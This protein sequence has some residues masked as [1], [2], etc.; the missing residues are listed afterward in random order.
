MFD[1]Q[2][3]LTIYSI[4]NVAPKGLKP[5]YKLVEIEPAYYTALRI[6]VTRLYAAKGAK[7]RIDGLVRCHSTEVSDGKVVVLGGK[8][9]QVSAS[10]PVISQDS[11]DITLTRIEKEYE[12]YQQPTNNTISAT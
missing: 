1:E 9:Y 3:L 12:I 7:E 11:V 6:G 2:G 10:Q 8:Q 5:D 4:E